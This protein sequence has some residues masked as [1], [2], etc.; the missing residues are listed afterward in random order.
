MK[1]KFYGEK[2]VA[3]YLG[4]LRRRQAWDLLASR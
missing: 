4:Q 3:F 2:Q 1:Q